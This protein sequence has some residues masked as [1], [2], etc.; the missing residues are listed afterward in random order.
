MAGS[1]FPQTP[2]ATQRLETAHRRIAT[3]LPTP[4]CLRMQQALSRVEARAMHGQLPMVWDRAEGHNVYDAQGNKWIDFTCSIFVT[5]VGHGNARVRR[6]LEAA[7]AKPLLHAYTYIT[8]E[9]VEYLEYL[10]ANTPASL[11]K[12]FCVSSGTE[13]TDCAL[14]LMRLHAVKSGK[15]RRGVLCFEGNWHGRT[16]GAQFLGHN[17]GQKEWIGHVDPD[18][19]HLPFPYPWRTEAWSDPRG[20]FRRGVEALCAAQGLDPAKDLCG[21]FLESYQGWG[22]FFYPEEFVQEAARFARENGLLLGFDEVQSGFGRTGELFA[23]QHYGVE[24]DLI[25]CGKGASGS[26]PLSMVLGRADIMDLPETGSMSSTHSAHPL[27]CV[28]GKAALEALL[29][30][31]LLEQGRERGAHFQ[32]RL[33]ALQKRFPGVIQHVAGRGLVAGLILRD[34][35]DK[36]LTALCDAVAFEALCRGLIVVHT[37]RESIKLA[38]PLSIPLDALD[39]GLDVLE[40]CLADC[41][42]RM[43]EVGEVGA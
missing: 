27:A 22:A 4:E 17:P 36:P 35:D 23:Y 7:V 12:A 38:P 6:A 26:V 8:R 13:A 21:L 40:Q 42:A 28:A 24:A 34:A 30:D 20:F 18:I 15:R 16:M 11:E 14:K 10:L 2:Q 25:C 39:E 3:D 5:N 9:R 32:A 1:G 33:A 31:G 41:L 37:G 19:H 43:G 29:V